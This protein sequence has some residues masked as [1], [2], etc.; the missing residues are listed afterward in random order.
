MM[1]Q[2]SRRVRIMRWLLPLLAL[3]VV[4]A[5]F[6]AGRDRG[7]VSAILTPAEIARLSAGLRLDAPRFAGQTESGEPFIIR[8]DWAEPDGTMPD[9]ITLER[10]TGEMTA[11][12]G[13]ILTGAAREGLLDRE[14]ER[15][16]LTGDVTVETS[17]GYRFET[18]TLE[19]DTANRKARSRVPVRATG[20]MGSLEAGSMRL[21]QGKGG[22]ASTQIWFENRVRLVFIPEGP[23]VPG[24]QGSPTGEPPRDTAPAPRVENKGG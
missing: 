2:Y 11:E 4:G 24:D 14:R 22:A 19:I 13:R 21:D 5:I 7:D 20:P 17:D 9:E 3:V 1:L 6:L 10:P 18:E 12:D 23:T 15:L 8:A 16:T